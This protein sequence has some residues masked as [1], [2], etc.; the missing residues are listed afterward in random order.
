MLKGTK[1]AKTIS[2]EV[3]PI[4]PDEVVLLKEAMIPDEVIEAFNECIAENWKGSY[5]IVKQK[6]VV[7]KIMKK[8]LAANKDPHIKNDITDNHWLDVEDIFRAAGWEVKYDGPGY[9]ESYDATFE[10]RKREEEHD[11]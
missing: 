10:F 5:A 4:T 8:F 9:N 2:G 6:Y 7:E 1:M 11:E 3:K